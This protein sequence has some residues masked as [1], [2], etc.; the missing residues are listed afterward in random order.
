[1]NPGRWEA[2]SSRRRGEDMGRK[3]LGILLT[4]VFEELDNNTGWDP[5]F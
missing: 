3:M 2:G 1:M 4:G 5:G